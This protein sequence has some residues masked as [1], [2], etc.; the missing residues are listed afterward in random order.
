MVYREGHGGRKRQSIHSNILLFPEFLE[1]F[2][3]NNLVWVGLG[4]TTHIQ[5][6]RTCSIN[7][8]SPSSPPRLGTSRR[9][10]AL[11]TERDLRMIGRTTPFL[12]H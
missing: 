2:K 12:V 7:A 11:P 9:L 6:L 8:H 3:V 10:L 4:W 5:S 1:T